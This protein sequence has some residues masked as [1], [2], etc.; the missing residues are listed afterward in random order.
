ML[1]GQRHITGVNGYTLMMTGGEELQISR[2][3]KKTFMTELAEVMGKD[4]VL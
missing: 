4:N 3:R 1:S 2:P